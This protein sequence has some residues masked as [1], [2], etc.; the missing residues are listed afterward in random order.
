[1]TTRAADAPAGAAAQ[2][3]AISPTAL[4]GA[5][6][7]PPERGEGAAHS[8]APQ[9]EE[10]IRDGGTDR[11]V[12]C[13]S[14]HENAQLARMGARFLASVRE[15]NACSSPL[16]PEAVRTDCLLWSQELKLL[17]PT[18]IV[19]A[20]DDSGDMAEARVLVDGKVIRESLDGRPIALDPGTHLIAVELPDGQ[21][22]GER[23][24]L[25]EGE[26]ERRIIFN[27]KSVPRGV[28][29][30]GSHPTRTIRPVPQAVY[31]L[32]ATAIV[33]LGLGVGFGSDALSKSRT[34]LDT[35]A[36]LCA[37]S[38][39]RAVSQRAIVADISLAIA[40]ASTIGAVA[41][42]VYR[43][44]RV[45]VLDQISASWIP[46]DRGGAFSLQGLF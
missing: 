17:I 31:V 26:R 8:V 37:A 27:L 11:I 25:A 46:S 43:P 42:Y 30:V 10:P 23:I 22:R 44:E 7:A 33:G 14:S 28:A 5:G 32:G 15:L 3:Q 19:I 39:S 1:M 41:T 35:C 2:G 20:E 6:S 16:C 38:V 36:P 34:A 12:A 18:V 21:T 4:E 9:G 45:V 24:V 13:L 29:S 40:L